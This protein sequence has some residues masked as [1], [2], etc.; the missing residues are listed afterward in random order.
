M[1]MTIGATHPM[2]GR[3]RTPKEIEIANTA[4]PKGIPRRIPDLRR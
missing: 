4:T 3:A 2:S 1:D